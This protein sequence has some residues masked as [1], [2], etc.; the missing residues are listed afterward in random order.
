MIALLVLLAVQPPA[1]VAGEWAMTITD[2]L[3][4]NYEVLLRFEQDDAAITGVT[5]DETAGTSDEVTGNVDG[6][7]ISMSYQADAPGLDRIRLAFQG[8]ITGDEMAGEVAF[9]RLA[10]GRWSAIRQVSTGRSQSED[11]VRAF[12]L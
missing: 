1:D 4:R 5:I 8:R 10:S 12:F 9:G 2:P 11:R 7:R 3:Q 6:E